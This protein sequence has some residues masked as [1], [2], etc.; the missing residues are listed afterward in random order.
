[1]NTEP[2]EKR[3]IPDNLGNPD[4]L[5]ATA[6]TPSSL[7]HRV[8]GGLL[9]TLS[10]YGV[11]AVFRLVIMV[12]LTRLLTPSDFGVASAAGVV[13]GLAGFFAEFGLFSVIEQRPVLEE[14][15][16]RTALTVFTL[17]GAVLG[18]IIFL[19]AP[20]VAAWFQ[21]EELLLPLRVAALIFPFIG[22]QSIPG[23][24]L[25]RN[26]RF[27]W[28]SGLSVVSY[29]LGIG[30][31]GI[32]MALMG[33]GLWSLVGGGVAQF[34][35]FT[36][37]VLVVQPFPKRPQLERQALRELTFFGGGFFL[38]RIF[39]YIGEQADNVIVGRWLG[40]SALGLYSRAYQLLVFPVGLFGNALKVV[41]MPSMARLQ[42]EPERLVPVYRRAVMLM[43]LVFLPISVAGLVLGREAVLSLFGSQ[44]TGVILP[45][46]V[47]AVGI[48]FRASY[49]ISDAM[50]QS[51]GAVYRRAGFAAVFAL[52]TVVGA[53]IGQNWGIVGV[54]AGIIV[55]LGARFLL[56]ARL[57]L[58]LVSMSWRD[59]WGAHVPGVLL[60]AT[61]FAV[62]W[63]L[64]AALRSLA[65]PAPIILILAGGG[66]ALAQGILVYFWP[67]LFLG[68]DGQYL[69]DTLFSYL[70]VKL[71]LPARAQAVKRQN[72]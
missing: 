60:A 69:R 2:V 30:L 25:K 4:E 54:A 45:F 39:A 49:T 58:Q 56:L 31:V 51:I 64:T 1:M 19:S 70:A 50:A 62:A 24:L 5:N 7:T 32:T 14:R 43:A 67:Q 44:W 29:T 37:A 6:A 8:I 66:T 26:L 53:L 41:L 47:L 59:F 63:P 27:N 68:Q 17:F 65:W 34:L 22:L 11:Q 28:L 46:Q 10:G 18:A 52:L 71:N 16:I 40:S 42:N 48:F 20:S 13:L 3:D 72:A 23:A 61:T 57:C 15:H 33:F 55:A 9:W 12:L 38:G 35:I 21:M 36:G